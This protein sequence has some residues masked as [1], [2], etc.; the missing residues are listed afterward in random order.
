MAT[1][2]DILDL[3]TQISDLVKRVDGLTALDVDA[4]LASMVQ[5]ILANQRRAQELYGMLQRMARV[6]DDEPATTDID[7]VGD[8]VIQ[9]E[10]V[11]D[12]FR[13]TANLPPEQPGRRY[14]VAQA[15]WDGS[16]VLSVKDVGPVL[17][18]ANAPKSTGAA[19]YNV[20]V[21]GKGTIST[22]DVLEVADGLL[23]MDGSGGYLSVVLLESNV[24]PVKLSGGA[25][26]QGT[27]TTQ[28]ARTYTVK[29][30]GDV[31]LGTAV[32]PTAAA[33]GTPPCGGYWKR[34]TLGYCIDATFGLAFREGSNLMLTWINEV[35]DAEACA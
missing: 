18:T 17:D 29:T 24:F 22:G 28:C 12:G 23:K 13:L 4:K 32:D 27:S 20:A 5:D 21:L 6:V 30:L 2:E 14:V 34:P 26:D 31:T 1:E 3:A 15:A 9:V 11:G 16:S 7:I 33:A 25:G 19:A 8:S 35:P 10:K